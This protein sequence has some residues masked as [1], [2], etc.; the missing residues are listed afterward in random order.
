[1]HDYTPSQSVGA[2]P[3]LPA[4]YHSGFGVA[5]FVISLV[6]GLGMV[7]LFVIAG[8][9]AS[10]APDGEIDA[11]S[12][13]AILLG[14]ALIGSLLLALLG[15]VLGIAGVVQKGCKKTF[16]VLGLVFNGL[17]VAGAVGLVLIGMAM[18]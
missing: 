8:V 2:P 7:L 16:A 15:A 1:M 12:S 17:I 4:Q 5:S 18:T 14:L 9:M 13:A 3:P 6:C 10:Q 11:Q